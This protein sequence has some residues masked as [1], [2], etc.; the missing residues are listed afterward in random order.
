[1]SEVRDKVIQIV[2]DTIDE[3]NET[4]KQPID[5]SDGEETPLY[6]KDSS[7]DSITLVNLISNIESTLEDDLDLEI[8]IVDERA[9]SQSRSPFRTIG[10][11]T[12]YIVLL[13]EATPTAD[14]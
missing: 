9:M 13:V 10:S 6:G 5:V 14:Q 2:F 12:D 7:V 4:L 3:L 1:V 8:I 11:L